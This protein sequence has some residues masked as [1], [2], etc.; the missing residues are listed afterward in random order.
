MKRLSILS[1]LFLATAAFGISTGSA[2][3]NKALKKFLK[4]E[5]PSAEMVEEGLHYAIETPGK[6]IKPKKGDYVMV[7]FEGKRLDG[8][9][10]DRS[11]DEP[12]VF[13]L[14]QRQ[15]IRGWDKSLELFSV[16]SQVKLFLAPEWAYNKVGAGKMVPPNTPVMFDLRIIKVLDDKAYDAYMVE[17]ENKEREQYEAMIEKR[18]KADKIS[19]HEYCTKNKIKVKRTRSGVSYQVTKKGKG[20]YPQVG[21]TAV[22]QYNGYFLDG[23]VFEK[24]TEKKPF[25]FIVGKNKIIK[26]LEEAI[27]FF[28]KGAEGFV[29][30]PSKLAYGPMPID[31]ENIKIPPHSV[32]IFKIKMLDIQMSNK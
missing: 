31:E 2:Q 13:Q 22:I 26:G 1:F 32:L 14:G 10:F 16:G 8:T 24:N 18:F 7:E 23:T 30:I 19:I 5:Y 29:V 20:T 6:G 27:A 12:F 17:L 3:E 15:V 4:K 9:V 28:N 25:S 21:E 11:E